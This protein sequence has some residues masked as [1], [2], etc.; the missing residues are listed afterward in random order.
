MKNFLLFILIFSIYSVKIDE[1]LFLI[2]QNQQF[3]SENSENYMTSFSLL[4]NK[5]NNIEFKLGCKNNFYSFLTSGNFNDLTL[6]SNELK[7]LNINPENELN[8]Y[9]NKIITEKNFEYNSKIKINGIYQWNLFNE[10]DFTNSNNG[11]SN[12]SVSTCGGV[13]MLG[14][15]CNF[16]EG[17]TFKIFENLPEHNYIKIE[18]NFHFIDNWDGETGY[19]KI[20]DNDGEPKYVWTESYTAFSGNNGVNICGGRMPEGKFSNPINV[21]FPH[22]KNSLKVIFGSTI[23]HDSCDESFGISGLKIYIR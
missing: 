3:D 11:W 9:S 12:N 5:D 14:G 17:E 6:F 20:E 15:Y 22:N 13:N 18:A 19:L 2:Q 4:G 23:M 21:I 10:E 16:G 1:K 8:I 7:I